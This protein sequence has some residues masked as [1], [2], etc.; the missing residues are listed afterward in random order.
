MLDKN[1]TKENKVSLN[2][3]VYYSKLY[4]KIKI[5]KQIYPTIIFNHF[6]LSGSEG[7]GSLVPISNGHCMRGGAHPAQVASSSQGQFNVMIRN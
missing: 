5:K 3:S 6:F 4:F 7:G 1:R 2:I